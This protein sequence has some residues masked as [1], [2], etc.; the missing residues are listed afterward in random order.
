[1]RNRARYAGTA[2][3]LLLDLFA[4]DTVIL[5]GGI[6]QTPEYL[7]A[8]CAAAAVR[9]SRYAD[10]SAHIAATGLGT[11]GLV[12]G[13]AALALDRFYRDPLAAFATA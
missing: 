6:L 8:V 9:S 4:P 3:G 5:D 7:D 13:A 11:G 10:P 1:L 12:R 2:V